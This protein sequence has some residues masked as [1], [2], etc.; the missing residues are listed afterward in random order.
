MQS[1]I[2]DPSPWHRRR[3]CFHFLYA[4]KDRLS[5]EK[6]ATVSLVGLLL[7]IV[8]DDVLCGF[9]LVYHELLQEHHGT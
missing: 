9:T 3:L 7:D 8:D 1:S 5:A 2:L 6:V 4:M